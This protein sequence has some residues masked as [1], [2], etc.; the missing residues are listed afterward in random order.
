MKHVI[1]LPQRGA[2]S[3]GHAVF[4]VAGDGAGFADV[5]VDGG[6]FCSGDF[7]LPLGEVLDCVDV[8]H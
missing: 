7:G 6:V 5:E 2:K 1:D 8:V 3:V 4:T